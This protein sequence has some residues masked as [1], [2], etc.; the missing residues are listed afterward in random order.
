MPDFPDVPPPVP[1][2][3]W[4]RP[5]LLRSWGEFVLMAAVALAI[6][7]WSSTRAAFQGSSHD[8][9]QMIASNHTLIRECAWEATFLSFFVL[10]LAWRGWKPA[11]LRIRIGWQSSAQGIALLIASEVAV[12]VA[13][14]AAMGIGY[15]LENTHHPFVSFV[16]SFSPHLPPHSIHVSWPVILVSMTVNAF[17]EEITCMGYIFNQLAARCGPGAALFVTVFLRVACHTYQDPFHLAAI[18]VLFSIYAA[19]YWYARKLWPLIFAHL[20][21]DIISVSALKLMRG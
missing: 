20:L 19:F 1:A 14:F 21:L 10:Y 12:V 3:D 7:I 2:R 5:E 16:L 13:L 11:D 8:F 18:A 17:L 9:M 15:A 6:P 4:L